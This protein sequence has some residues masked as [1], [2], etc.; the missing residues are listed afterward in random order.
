MILKRLLLPVAALAGLLL[1]VVYMAGGFSSKQAPEIINSERYSGATHQIT[2]QAVINKVWLPATVSARQNTQVASRI[3]ATI[4]KI[5][6]RA[7]HQV[8]QGQLIAELDNQDLIK[9]VAQLDARIA[10]TSAQLVQAEAQ[11]QRNKALFQ[12]GLI[13]S[14]ELDDIQASFDKLSATKLSE[15]Q[16]RDQ[17]QVTLSYSKIRAPISGTV[18]DRFAEPGDLA[19]PGQAIVSIYNPLSMQL[20]AAVPESHAVALGLGQNIAFSIDSINYSGESSVSEIVPLVDSSARSFAIKLDVEATNAMRPGMY[21][22]IAIEKPMRQLIAIPAASV[23]SFGQLDKVLVIENGVAQARFVRLG[24][25][26]SS[27]SIEVIAGLQ[28]GEVIAL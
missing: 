16:L 9:Q 6:V 25:R 18:V 10:A 5:H 3:L 15:Q 7:G 1:I 4:N 12:Q 28:A 21:A 8:K 22:R 17:A 2:T 27:G 13:S 26:L 11:L 24:K 14:S 23:K 19:N 20:S